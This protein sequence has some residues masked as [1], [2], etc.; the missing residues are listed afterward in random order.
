MKFLTRNSRLAGV[1][2]AFAFV[3]S[4]FAGAALAET[5]AELEKMPGY[6]EFGALSILEGQEAKV[7]VYLK[8]PMLNLVAKFVKEE[9]PELFDV[10]GK[11]KL[12][13]VMVFD[14]TPELAGEISKATSQTAKQL[15]DKGWERI[16]RVRDEGEHVDVYLK[17]S[18]DYET[19]EGIVVMVVGEDDEAIFVNIVGTID[20][21]DLDK[22]GSHFDIDG[23]DDIDYDNY[24]KKQNGNG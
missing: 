9:D 8:D 7:E 18:A 21:S 12:V 11:L 5:E 13:R 19:L 23:L 20:P 4:A 24:K 2:L 14:V 10:L 3:C 22:L 6:V 16:V 17:P 15:D 1:A